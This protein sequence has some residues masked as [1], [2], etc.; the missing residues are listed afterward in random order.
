MHS[1]EATIQSRVK[2]TLHQTEKELTCRISFLLATVS[3]SVHS[4]SLADIIDNKIDN[5]KR[6]LALAQEMI[7]L[8]SHL[9]SVPGW[10]GQVWVLWAVRH[11][12]LPSDSLIGQLTCRKNLPEVTHPRTPQELCPWAARHREQRCKRLAQ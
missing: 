8:L 7:C 6:I 5:Y 1:A 4:E 2:P 11:S 12:D 9:L 3:L 10:D